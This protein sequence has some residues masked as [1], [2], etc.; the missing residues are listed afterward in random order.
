MPSRRRQPSKAPERKV[1]KLDLASMLEDETLSGVRQLSAL[2]IEVESAPEPP[3]QDDPGFV[4]PVAPL[5]VRPSGTGITNASSIGYDKKDPGIGKVSDPGSVFKEDPE[6]IFKQDPESGFIEDPGS[7]LMGGREIPGFTLPRRS[8]PV[9][10]VEDGLHVGE[11]QLLRFLWSEGVPDGGDP[12]T[13]LVSLG[14][15][16]IR[17]QGAPGERQLG[18]STVKRLLKSLARKRCVVQCEAATM[19]TPARWKIYS[20]QRILRAWRESGWNEVVRDRR[21]VMLWTGG[22]S[23]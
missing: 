4:L 11:L 6:S 22:G 21:A 20:D 8:R 1:I 16:T 12:E 18:R 5:P 23:K 7:S 13:R 14:N 10:G 15:A 19:R 2:R 9:R 3:R 17:R